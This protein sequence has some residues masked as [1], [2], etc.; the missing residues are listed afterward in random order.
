[1]AGIPDAPWV[2]FDREEYEERCNPYSHW[3]EEADHEAEEA[4]RLWEEERERRHKNDNLNS[5]DL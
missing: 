2:G 3:E 5:N 4:D 1:M